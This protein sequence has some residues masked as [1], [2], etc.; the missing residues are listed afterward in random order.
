[1][2]LEYSAVVDAL[3]YEN[4]AVPDDAGPPPLQGEVWMLGRR[5]SL[6]GGTAA[7]L[8]GVWS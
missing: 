3:V 1:M 6:P 4:M 2:A 8:G 5:Y 7:W